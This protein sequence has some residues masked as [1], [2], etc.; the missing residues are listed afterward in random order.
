MM[1]AERLEGK[2]GLVI[3]DYSWWRLQSEGDS[4]LQLTP[5]RWRTSPT[6][7]LYLPVL[8]GLSIRMR[9]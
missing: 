5:R 1:I 2:Q 9:R 6:V 3:C 7:H 8:A 4:A